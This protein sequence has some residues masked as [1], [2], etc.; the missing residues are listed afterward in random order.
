MTGLIAILLLVSALGLTFFG[1]RSK[2][3]NASAED[4]MERMGRFATREDFLAVVDGSGKKDP[5]KIAQS[6][7]QMVKGRTVA[8]RITSVLVR[9]DVRLTIGEF[10]LIRVLCAGGGF[11]LGFVFL[12]RF[13]PALGVLMGIATG[14]IGYAAPMFYMNFK[15][16]QRQKRFV[17]QLGDTITLMANSLRAGYSLLQTMDLV[18]RETRDP[19]SV[20]FKRVVHEIGLGITNEDAMM[21]L[22][23]RVPSDDLD[24]LVSAINIQH[25]V[26][27]NLAQILTIIGHTIRERVRIKGEIKV[28]VAQ[29]QLSG[30]VV[31][32][33][34]VL[35]ALVIFLMN[36]GYLTPLFSWPYICMPI[37]SVIMIILGYI[38][39]RKITAIEV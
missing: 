38:I 16:K 9:A 14:F 4:V 30:L 26:G 21:N 33:L 36:P 23:R 12:A 17:N 39:M 18:S 32:A 24:L 13:A 5:S 37:S 28:L 35:L 27:G 19:I 15:A 10:L 3:K 7:E 29:V 8:E 25:E 20:E 2:R 1:V 31:T 34:P 22:L 11:V 6:L